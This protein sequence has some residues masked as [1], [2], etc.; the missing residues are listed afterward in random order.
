MMTSAG[1]ANLRDMIINGAANPSQV[2]SDRISLA[3]ASTAFAKF[4]QR[5]SANTRNSQA[6]VKL[7]SRAQKQLLSVR[8]SVCR[9][10]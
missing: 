4:E 5:V 10:R 3:Q 9:N 7:W 1:T 6:T 8:P 2:V